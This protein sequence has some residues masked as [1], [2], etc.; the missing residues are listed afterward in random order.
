MRFGIHMQG[1]HKII[2]QRP[3]ERHPKGDIL[4][5]CMYIFVIC[6]GGSG[7]IFVR[8]GQ[9]RVLAFGLWLFWAFKIKNQA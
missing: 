6:R 8:S 4:R 1:R 5:K 3:L 7:L 9:G 2:P